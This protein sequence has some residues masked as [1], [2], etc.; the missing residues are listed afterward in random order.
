MQEEVHQCTRFQVLDRV[1]DALYDML[2]KL[3]GDHP[4]S[5]LSDEQNTE[6]INKNLRTTSAL[7]SSI[8]LISRTI[9][10]GIV[11]KLCGV[12]ANGIFKNSEVK[13]MY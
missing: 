8:K 4:H 12:E 9:L 1:G 3:T 11:S 10:E 6:G 2:C 5:P 7:Q 13:A